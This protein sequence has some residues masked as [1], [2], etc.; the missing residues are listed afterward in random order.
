MTYYEDAEL[1][2]IRIF[3]LLVDS[4]G[5]NYFSPTFAFSQNHSTTSGAKL[6]TSGAKKYHYMQYRQTINTVKSGPSNPELPH[7]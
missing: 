5:L 2:E 6:T 1:S 3:R 7:L 4:L